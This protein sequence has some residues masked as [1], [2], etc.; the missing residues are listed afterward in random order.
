MFLNF[1]VGG[2]V[3]GPE[4]ESETVHFHPFYVPT[5]FWGPSTFIPLWPPTQSETVHYHLFKYPRI[6]CGPSNLGALDRPLSPSR[7]VRF[8]P[9][10]STF[11]STRIS[12]NFANSGAKNIFRWNL[13]LRRIVRF[14]G[15]SSKIMTHL[16]H[17]NRV[18]VLRLFLFRS[19]LGTNSKHFLKSKSD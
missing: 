6:F 10:L 18:G 11:T 5:H 7:T 14:G 13:K 15:K 12:Q 1:W 17:F 9:G 19:Q 3:D 16:T 2:K 4:S 8:P